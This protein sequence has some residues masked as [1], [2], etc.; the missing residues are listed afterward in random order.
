MLGMVSRFDAGGVPKY[1]WAV[2]EAGDVY[3]A[4]TSPER[5]RSYHG[6]RLGDDERDMREL[7]LNEWKRRVGKS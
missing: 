2:D 6:Y 5:E 3:E 7:I 1:I 4:K